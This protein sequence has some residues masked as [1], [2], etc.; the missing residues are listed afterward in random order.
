MLV[1][2]QSSESVVMIH[3]QKHKL[4]HNSIVEGSVSLRSKA[5]LFSL[6]N[7]S[8]IEGKDFILDF[9]EG[10]IHRTPGSI[11]PD[12]STNVLYGVENFDHTQYDEYGNEPFTLY[13]DYGYLNHSIANNLQSIR[14][15]DYMSRTRS[16]LQKGEEITYL[17]YGDSISTGAEA[18]REEFKYFHR[19]YDEIQNQYPKSK[20]NMMMKAIGGEDSIGGLL[21]LDHDVLSFKPDLISIGYGMNDQNKMD[22][23]NEVP[24]DD[25]QDNL[26][27]IIESIKQ[28]TI[29]EIILLTPCIP[30]PLWKHSS[31]DAGKYA[32]VLRKLG[33]EYDIGVAD[34]QKIWSLEIDAGKTH[35]S[36][37]TNNINHPNDYGHSLYFKALETVLNLE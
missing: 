26:R 16:K 35:E 12:W 37:L 22:N 14:N 1:C 15:K 32:D 5:D 24:L 31:G 34:L 7:I 13:I 10:T 20:V 9:Q 2:Q 21:R 3:C 23:G 6:D 17:I 33:N 19:F 28:S 36:L 11:I 18:S 27:K 8:Y 29:A 25:F 30:N 4:R